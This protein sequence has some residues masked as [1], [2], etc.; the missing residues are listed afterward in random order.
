MYKL[1]FSQY[2][3]ETK[4]SWNTRYNSEHLED[5]NIW[6]NSSKYLVISNLGL[7][8]FGDFESQTL[9]ALLQQR[10]DTDKYTYVFLEK[11]KYSLLGKSDSLFYSK[12]KQE[13]KS[14]GVNI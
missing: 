9:L 6:I 14:R 10:Y 11:G 2:L 5:V 8:R 7:I 4:K 3:D 1:N 12:L 13:F